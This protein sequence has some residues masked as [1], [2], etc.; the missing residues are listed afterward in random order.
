[1]LSKKL[2]KAASDKKEF[3]RKEKKQVIR[4]INK[5]D[6]CVLSYLHLHMY[7]VNNYI[8]K[9][10]HSAFPWNRRGKKGNEGS[11]KIVVGILK[12]APGY[13]ATQTEASVLFEYLLNHLGSCW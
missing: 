4:T 2:N 11:K 9:G 8:K 5:K 6:T 3:T 1:M 12:H 7:L 13:N 10:T